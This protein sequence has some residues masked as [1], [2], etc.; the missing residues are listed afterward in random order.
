MHYCMKLLTCGDFSIFFMLSIMSWSQAL[1]SAWSPPAILVNRRYS[2]HSWEQRNRKSCKTKVTG[3]HLYHHQTQNTQKFRT[4]K[5]KDT[6]NGRMWWWPIRAIPWWNR[7]GDV[8]IAGGGV[9]VGVALSRGNEPGVGVGVGV[10]QNFK[11]FKSLNMTF[12]NLRSFL[13]CGIGIFKIK[14]PKSEEKCE[15][16]GR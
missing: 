9:G 5:L 3:A 15:F 2:D 16:G 1:I 10:D 12:K 7:P 8:I 4:V 13:L 6:H 14:R 11:I